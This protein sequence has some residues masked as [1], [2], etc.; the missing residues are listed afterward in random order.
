MAR[1]HPFQ[2]PFEIISDAS[3]S[4]D[5]NSPHH[6]ELKANPYSPLRQI[7]V[8]NLQ[9][10]QPCT[11][12]SS[13]AELKWVQTSPEAHELDQ[14]NS[15]PNW[16]SKPKKQAGS[17]LRRPSIAA[18]TF[19]LLE[20]VPE[21]E[22]QVST[23]TERPRVSGATQ[24][25]LE[26]PVDQYSH[27]PLSVAARAIPP[28]EEQI[29]KHRDGQFEWVLSIKIPVQS[30][31]RRNSSTSDPKRAPRIKNV[32]FGCNLL[33]TQEEINAASSQ[34]DAAPRAYTFLVTPLEESEELLEV[35]A[36]PTSEGKMA[37]EEPDRNHSISI[38]ELQ[39]SPTNE[40]QR[41]I[42][43]ASPAPAD[44]E[45]SFA[46][47]ITSRSP[48]KPTARI[49]DSVAALDELEEQL[50][51]FDEAAHFR[52]L[53]SPRTA[54]PASKPPARSLSVRTSRAGRS[55]T[56][57]PKRSTPA[58]SGAASVRVK[59]AS[60]PR[61][62]MVRKSASM[63]F[64][65]PPKL[66]T[67][68]KPL[69]QPPPKKSTANNVASLLPPKQPARSNK[70]PTIPSFRLPGEEVAQ[71]LKQKREAR[72][73]A[74]AAAEQATR[75]TAS[76]LRRAKS[77]KPATRPTFELPGEAISR[78]KRE[79]REAQL[80]AQEEEERKRREFKARPI[81]SGVAPGTFP[82]GTVASRARQ[83]RAF[84]AE[85]PEQ[86]SSPSSNQQ[87]SKAP[88]S[89]SRSPLSKA[90]NQSQSRGRE[91]HPEPSWS[92]ASHT[93]STTRSINSKCSNVS[94]D[95][96]Q[97]QKLRGQEIY[98]RDN[99]WISDRERERRE[100]E[101][102]AKL[103]REEAAERSRQQSREWAAKQAKKRMTVGSL[104]DVVA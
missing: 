66:K 75:P 101:A 98:Q 55:L 77:A 97:Q 100:R 99:S 103:A 27:H 33:P 60:E 4:E 84:L 5:D 86:K 53:V 6:H 65:D 11:A 39:A 8:S 83:T 58:K 15:A 40:A 32:F 29:A 104:R 59:P 62:P 93:S 7:S 95:E 76:S 61:Q 91:L 50:E 80:K 102:L 85:N 2:A 74:Q 82:R 51:A 22:T 31:A 35:I 36:E 26:L 48:A 81:R 88:T 68:G 45:D 14:V 64:L 18:N 46:E 73:A 78:R 21:D 23:E 38:K 24:R 89:N 63:I 13:T 30:T 96:V 25:Y 10:R 20:T 79:E 34:E 9:N 71:Q 56:P 94:T 57:Q 3:S 17:R 52:Q 1:S 44:N 12:S 43:A 37:L 92:Q 28:A 67:E 16:S 54:D 42:L 69:A 87:V 19:E 49:E 72:L 90:N 41:P 70:L 47:V